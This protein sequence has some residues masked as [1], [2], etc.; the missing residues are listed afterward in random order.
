MCQGPNLAHYGYKELLH[1]T[2]PFIRTTFKN[3][4]EH[5]KKIQLCL[6]TLTNEHQRKVNMTNVRLV[7]LVG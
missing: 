1:M 2:I 7:G 5:E 6:T 3:N 4:L